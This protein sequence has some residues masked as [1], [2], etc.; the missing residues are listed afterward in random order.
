MSDRVSENWNWPKGPKDVWGPPG[1]NWLHRL[2]I[3]YPERPSRADARAAFRRLWSFVTHLPCDEC[4]T[5]ATR[6]VLGHPPDLTST[7]AFQSWA[8]AFHNHANIRLGKRVLTYPEYRILYG[9]E[10]AQ[11]AARARR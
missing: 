7:Q 1:W 8:W 10:I 6:Y 11:A 3:D 9:D 5:H 4:R 2:A